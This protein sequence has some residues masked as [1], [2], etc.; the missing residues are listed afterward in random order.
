MTKNMSALLSFPRGLAASSPSWETVHLSTSHSLVPSVRI[1]ATSIGPPKRHVLA[2]VDPTSAPAWGESFDGR[3]VN[4]DLQIQV[5]G[6]AFLP[7]L[8]QPL[9]FGKFLLWEVSLP[10]L[11]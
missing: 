6:L 5:L 7:P 2:G 4:K 1:P 11:S 8:I 3:R 10:V 9:I